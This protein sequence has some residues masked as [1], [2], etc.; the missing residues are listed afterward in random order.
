MKNGPDKHNEMDFPKE[1]VFAAIS[2]GMQKGKSRK[3]NKQHTT[4]EKPPMS[5]TV[6]GKILY[7][8]GAAAVFIALFM[9]TAY[10]SPA[11]ASA[12]SNIPLVGSIFSDNGRPGLEQASEKELTNAIGET[13]TIDGTSIT[14]KEVLYDNSRLTISYFLESEDAI[15]EHYFSG[16][17]FRYKINGEFPD[18]S[19][20]GHQATTLSPTSRTGIMEFNIGNEAPDQFN[21]ELF[22]EADN[23][24]EWEFS[25]PVE[26][27][28]GL[29]TFAVNHNQ[30]AGNI[31]LHVSDM[32]ISS[33]GISLNYK[34]VS[35]APESGRI[36]RIPAQYLEFH[37]TDE[38]GEE[39]TSYSGG[40]SGTKKNGSI[41]LTGNKL[42]DPIG[43]NVQQLTITP[44][45]KLP[46]DG[47]GVKLE[48]DGNKTALNGDISEL[49]NVEFDPFTVEAP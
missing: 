8:A 44:Y 42:F 23:G 5:K 45:L 9:G 15:G 49:K 12:V 7:M 21:F 28:E 14:M 27:I 4:I 38:N 18:G 34:T 32:S 20:G 24:K 25:F 33:S 35:P 39:V 41:H 37:I 19:S 16:D 10:F 47:G 31:D 29:K 36:G 3:E 11:F 1:E 26:T 6:K 22:M 2:K 40:S 13:Q 46:S 43:E 17:S 30:T 48:Q